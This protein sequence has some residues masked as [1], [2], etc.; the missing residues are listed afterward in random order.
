M[1]N[2]GKSMKKNFFDIGNSKKKIVVVDEENNE[3]SQY[4]LNRKTQHISELFENNSVVIIVADNCLDFISCYIAAMNKSNV[5]TL[6]LDKTFSTEYIQS[7]IKIYKPNYIFCP[8]TIE[9]SGFKI[10]K[11]IKLKGF[12]ILKT[13]EK[14]EKKLNFLNFL[15]LS[16]SGST[17]SPKFVRL[18]KENIFDNTKKIIKSLRIKKNHTTITTMP[19]GYSYGL[20]I[21]NTHLKVGAKIVLNNSTVF[22][23]EFWKKIRKFRVN[24]FGGVPEF[25]DILKKIDFRK[26]L[27]KD[28]RY[29]TQAGGRLNESTLNYLGNVSK[30][31]NIK[32][33][34]M[35][36]QTEASPRMTCLDW[37][38]FFK[39]FNSVGKPLTGYEIKIVKN[40]KEIKK[41]LIKGEILFKGNNV[42]LGYAKNFNDLKKG[43]TNG[44]ILYTGDIGFQDK[45]NFIF[46]TGRSK[47]IVKIFGKRFNLDDIER[48]TQKEGQDVKCKIVDNKLNLEI[49]AK[50]LNEEIVINKISKKFNLNKNFIIISKKV[51]TFKSYV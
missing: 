44:R 35:Y 7:L 21:I 9:L 38:F 33:F 36:G 10:F 41:P 15:L 29:F 18:S 14:I 45:D 22:E 6:L 11:I 31:K 13:K 50:N 27:T 47:R 51:K 19:A 49:S 46:L 26:Y 4:E 32:F 12:K 23:R 43:N 37:K 34:V 16:T 1:H 17:Q 5:I 40:R 25:Y 8:K 24:S 3:I 2:S 48:Y 42:S 20:S 28:I 39:K 30:E